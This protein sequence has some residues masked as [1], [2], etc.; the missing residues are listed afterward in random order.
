MPVGLFEITLISGE[1]FIAYTVFK[2]YWGRGIAVEATQAVIDY[3]K[4]KFSVQRFVIEMDTRNRSSVKVAEKLG[5]TFVKVTNNAQ[6]VKNFVS[7]D[8]Q[9][10]LANTLLLSS[11]SCK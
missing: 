5:F 6:F 2:H 1:A 10:E 11:I 7:H 4:R 9:F 3:I 8:F